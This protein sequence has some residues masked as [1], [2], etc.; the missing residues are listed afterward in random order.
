VKQLE[1]I[2]MN[3][4][5]V[6]ARVECVVLFFA[7]L[8]DAHLLRPMLATSQPAE[9]LERAFS[10]LGFMNVFTPLEPEGEW[11]LD[12]RVPEQH[13]VAAVLLELRTYE[14]DVIH[15][16]V[17][18]GTALPFVPPTWFDE[19]PTDV[20][21]QVRLCQPPH[22]HTQHKHTHTPTHTHTQ[23]HTH[24]HAHTPTIVSAVLSGPFLGTCTHLRTRHQAPSRTVSADDGRCDRS[25]G[26]LKDSA[27]VGLQ[28]KY[29]IKDERISCADMEARKRLAGACLI[30]SLDAIIGHDNVVED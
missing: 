12:L 18:D 17:C 7:R 6:A 20:R 27:R 3:F 19:L 22:A 13:A 15:E 14:G 5:L 11:H 26:A 2:L 23:T 8:V 16:L 28:F 1:R 24:T 30:N 9:V 4:E 25:P 29:E 10:R 21:L